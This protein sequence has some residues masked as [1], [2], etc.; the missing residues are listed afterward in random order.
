MDEAKTEELARFV[1]AHSCVQSD[2]EPWQGYY[3]VRQG[4]AKR[5]ARKAAAGVEATTDDRADLGELLQRIDSCLHDGDGY[6]WVEAIPHG[7][8]HPVGSVR[9]PCEPDE[10]AAAVTVADDGAMAAAVAGM[11]ETMRLQRDMLT[12]TSSAYRLL[13]D[14]TRQRD[15]DLALTTYH[16][17]QLEEGAHSLAVREAVEAAAPLVRDV[18]PLVIGALLAK[19]GA[20]PPPDD[21]TAAAGHHVAQLKAAAAALAAHAQA[22]PETISDALRAELAEVVQAAA[23]IIMGGA[24]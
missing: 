9:I 5:T 15:V 3:R 24:P 21:P 8:S 19:A 12:D 11:L 1:R 13:L 10:A 2:G 22:H 6:I 17:H 7:E 16:A 18:A 20:T 4:T 23:P 14:Q